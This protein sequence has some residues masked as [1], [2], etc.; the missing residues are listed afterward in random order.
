MQKIFQNVYMFIYFYFLIIKI[1]RVYL[2]GLIQDPSILND[3]Q[4][5]K[6]Q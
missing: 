6:G 3:F 5:W 4:N 1:I 2:D